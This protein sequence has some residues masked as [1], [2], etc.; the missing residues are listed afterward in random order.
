VNLVDDPSLGVLVEPVS[1]VEGSDDGDER[2]DEPATTRVTS[3]AFLWI[4]A[5]FH[6]AAR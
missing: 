3:S 1:R 6:G 5:G 2:G 4:S